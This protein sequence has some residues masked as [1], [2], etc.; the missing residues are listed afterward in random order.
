MSVRLSIALLAL[1]TVTACGGGGGGG[2]SSVLPVAVQR[3]PATPAPVTIP[4]AG[5]VFYLAQSTASVVSGSV[6]ASARAAMI[7]VMSSAP[8]EHAGST[9]TFALDSLAINN[10]ATALSARRLAQAGRIVPAP[11]TISPVEVAPADD[12]RVHRLLQSLPHSTAGSHVMS[13]PRTAGFAIN[14]AVG[15]TAKIWAAHFVLG[16]SAA[17]YVQIPA[18]LAA[19]TPHANIWIDQAL[20][21]GSTSSSAF[22]AGALKGTAAQIGT[23]FENAYASDSAHFAAPDYPLGSAGARTT[24]A[25]CDAG[26]NQT[27]STAEYINEPSDGRVNVMVLDSGALGS[28]V[29]G[30]FSAVNYVP[31]AAWNC[32]KSNVPKSNEAPF[33]YVGWF[34]R[35]GSSYEL[36][37]DLVR[38]TAH[39]LQHLINFVNHSILAGSS[40]DEDPF[41]NEGLSMLAQDLAVDRMF[42]KGFDV[43]DALEHASVYLANPQNYSISGFIGVDPQSWS[44]SGSA[45]FNCGG[46]CYG[47]A[48]LF[49]R[50]L[51]DR[52]GGDAYTH[53][54]ETGSA[55][56]SQ[57]LMAATGSGES[58]GTLFDDFAMALAA[59]S[60]HVTPA[61]ARF[62]FG[63]LDVTGTYSDQLGATHTLSGVYSTQLGG[64]QSGDV[65]A[66][67]GGFAFVTLA[68]NVAGTPVTVTDRQTVAG[69]SL[70]GGIAQH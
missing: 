21:A 58:F 36:Q 55:V 10:G 1:C 35:N 39:E 43:A 44:G 54:M 18:T 62:H 6:G 65:Q 60:M 56:S 42:G 68:G 24:V 11:R 23:D 28:G 26:G 66:P 48:Y 12:A 9:S 29:G 25:T 38:G 50:Y 22:A 70:A 33:I 27:G 57:G 46:G 17:T 14:A 37:E 49:Q 34:D 7:A 63:T 47:G 67:V 51:Y 3:T 15:T 5:P 41:I 31:Q 16:N 4:A 53:K 52:F 13:L 19:Q 61:D 8:D 69:F 30:Y 32:L 59:N 45:Q 40:A 20:L 2:S 64:N